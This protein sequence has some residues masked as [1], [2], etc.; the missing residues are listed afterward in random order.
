MAG[1]SSCVQFEHGDVVDGYKVQ[2]VYHAHTHVIPTDFQV[3][4]HVIEKF[5]EAGHR[6]EEVNF[7]SM[8]TIRLMSKRADGLNYYLLR[9][10]EHGA[11]IRGNG[12][13]PSQFFQAMVSEIMH[14]N[15]PFIDWKQLEREELRVIRRRLYKMAKWL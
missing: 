12:D 13:I 3:L 10:N 14:P 4:P 8:G 7:D 2:S 5:K 6:V 11:F 15:Y 9:Q 1:K